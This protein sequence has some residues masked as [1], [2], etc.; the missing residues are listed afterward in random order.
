MPGRSGFAGEMACE[1]SCD[2]NDSEA[3]REGLMMDDFIDEAA[4]ERKRVATGNGHEGAELEA[5][6]VDGHM[7]PRSCVVGAWPFFDPKRGKPRA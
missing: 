5:G 7:K 3:M 2:R 6:K 4:R 1:I